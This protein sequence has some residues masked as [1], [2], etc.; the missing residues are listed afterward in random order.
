[1][2]LSSR[3]SPS[4][5]P[6]TRLILTLVLAALPAA[7]EQIPHFQIV[8]LDGRIYTSE[9]EPIIKKGYLFLN[10]QQSSF[11]SLPLET[12]DWPATRQ[13]NRGELPRL[14]DRWEEGPMRY[15]LRP[16][17]EKEYR[18]LTDDA[19]RAAWI[20]GFWGSLD[21]DPETF[22]NERRFEYWSRVE[23]ANALF[24]DSTKPGWMTDRGK[25]YI[26]LG[27]PDEIESF[28][29]RS[30][31]DARFDPR[32][33]REN[34]DY[35]RHTLP[36]RSVTRWTYRQPPGE[37][38]DPGTIIAFRED[39]SGEYYLSR[40]GIDYDRIFRDVTANLMSR[41]QPGGARL[42]RGRDSQTVAEK[43]A[44]MG[45]VGPGVDALSTLSLLA[46]LGRIQQQALERDWLQEVVRTRE[47]FGVFP[48]RSSHHFYRSQ[49]GLTYVE[50]N[51]AVDEQAR[52]PAGPRGGPAVS[53][54]APYSLS[55]RLISNADPA[56]RIEFD[57][58]GGFAATSFQEE[59]QDRWVFQSGAGVAP[60]NYTLLVAIVAAESNRIGSWREAVEVPDLSGEGLLLSD[61]MLASRV[62]TLIDS[63]AGAYKQPFVHGRL[64][65]V[66][67]IDRTYRAGDELGFY[68]QVYGAS[69]EA[70][71]GRTSLDLLYR[72][73]RLEAGASLPLGS[74]VSLQEQHE[75]SQAFT[76]PLRNWP[77]GSYRLTVKVIDRVTG[78]STE[79][80]ADFS[81]RD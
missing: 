13:A 80:Q 73:E 15:I 3:S 29:F 40:E 59:G 74:P 48:V 11:F 67:D 50:I 66:P 38:L 77:A 25:F 78:R 36:P 7:A 23:R 5:R 61:L 18:S 35:P 51:L 14:L 65:V 75:S 47:F 12:I 55:A 26:L 60:G 4:E 19:H 39:S 37:G 20:S 52:T 72:F 63:P 9:V 22:F 34:P 64:R 44:S 28:P 81:V 30:G 54:P 10:D 24:A 45:R 1:M 42:P 16:E 79:R 27:P 8:T 70:A 49:E 21:P 58:A 62:E 71:T 6:V 76:L 46:D 31:N 56:R 2:R 17:Q 32:F 69:T 53:P 43:T 68:Y 41:E 33:V 57:A